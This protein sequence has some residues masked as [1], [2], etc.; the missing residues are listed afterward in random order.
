MSR[1]GHL[2]YATVDAVE[3]ALGEAR[4]AISLFLLNDT[5]QR[6]IQVFV[7]RHRRG[8]AR[9]ELASPERRSAFLGKLCHRH[10][11]ILDPRFL[12]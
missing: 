2:R 5:E 1:S 12:F 3:P 7:R 4:A 9:F 8:C 10:A 6:F 11:D